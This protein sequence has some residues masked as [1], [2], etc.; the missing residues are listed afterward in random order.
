[1]ELN[2]IATLRASD[3]ARVFVTSLTFRTGD[4]RYD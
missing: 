4:S 1:V 2:G 3:Y